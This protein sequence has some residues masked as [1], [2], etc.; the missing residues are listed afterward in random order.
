MK[1]SKSKKRLL[2][3][4]KDFIEES[5]KGYFKPGYFKGQK[6]SQESLHLIRIDTTCGLVLPLKN[7]NND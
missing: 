5:S 7:K 4:E 3:Q 6:L 2:E 1:K